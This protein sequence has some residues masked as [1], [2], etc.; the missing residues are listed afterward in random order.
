MIRPQ[1]QLEQ[2]QKKTDEKLKSVVAKMKAL[3]GL[4]KPEDEQ[5]AL[6]MLASRAAERS[7]SIA[8]TQG[9]VDDRGKPSPVQAALNFSATKWMTKAEEAGGATLLVWFLREAVGLT[10]KGVAVTTLDAAAKKSRELH[11]AMALAHILR[12]RKPLWLWTGGWLIQ[13][14]I[15]KIYKSQALCTL[16]AALM[17]G[18]PQY[19]TLV[20]KLKEEADVA[21]SKPPDFDMR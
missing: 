15:Y 11:A 20:D 17:P 6:L 16:A 19:R 8:T 4:E 13:Y 2:V 10:R 21:A 9:G 7:D 12:A 1:A 18:L 14:T 5:R 3:V